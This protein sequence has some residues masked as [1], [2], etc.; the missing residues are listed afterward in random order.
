M[1][2]SNMIEDYSTSIEISFLFRTCKAANGL[3]ES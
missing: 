1:I 3:V 2:I